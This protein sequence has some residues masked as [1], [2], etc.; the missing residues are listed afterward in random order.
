MS[1]NYFLL[2]LLFILSMGC[3]SRQKTSEEKIT[4]DCPLGLIFTD[5]TQKDSSSNSNNY[6]LDG[7][8]QINPELAPVVKSILKLEAQLNVS[9]KYQN[10]NS[11]NSSVI[12][13]LENKPS[14]ELLD[15][16]LL[17]R[18]I[19]CANHRLICESNAIADSSKIERYFYE[20]G[21][22]REELRKVLQSIRPVT[23]PTVTDIEKTEKRKGHPQIQSKS[24][25][26]VERKNDKI[27][28]P[29]ALIITQNQSGGSNTVIN[30]K[31][32]IPEPKFS[33]KI[34][35][36]NIKS[37]RIAG[38]RL[39]DFIELPNESIKQP[40]VYLTKSL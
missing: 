40:F 5:V 38:R 26:I 36:I 23:I 37:T 14:Q 7:K 31:I 16:Y 18:E 3:S 19:F 13:K 27:D 32:D 35:S 15:A 22:L 29:N 34:D 4:C 9:G 39:F 10:G 12:K 20:L 2:F 24:T 21:M 30:P 33:W 11:D 25:E 17:E 8:I 6:T 1:K 28:A